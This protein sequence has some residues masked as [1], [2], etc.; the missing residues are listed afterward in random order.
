MCEFCIQHGSGKKWYLASKNYAN[1]LGYSEERE[2]FIKDFFKNYE[3]NYRKN[4]NMAEIASKIPFIKGYAE[5]KVKNYFT[6]KHAGQVI[7]LEDAISICSIAGRVSI[8]DCPCQKY[9]FNKKEKKCILFGSTAEIV[10]NLPEFSDLSDL[11]L[12]DAI[13]L[14]KY[15]ES[16]GKIHTIWTFMSPYIGA[17]CNCNER[18]CLMFHL[19]KQ[20][21]FTEIIIK[22]HEVGRVNQRLCIGCGSCQKVCQFQ[23]IRFIGK[24]AII[25]YNCHGCGICRRFCSAGAIQLIP[26]KINKSEKSEN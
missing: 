22:G 17:M 20:Y 10:E 8:M 6:Q 2:S 19:K 5:I 15:V 16:E 7:P 14:L 11:G 26:R 4:V 18:K 9:L 1:K 13:E 12:E 24:K 25:N 3:K 21:K 23:G